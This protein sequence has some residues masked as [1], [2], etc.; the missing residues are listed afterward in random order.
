MCAALLQALMLAHAFPGE[1]NVRLIGR[2]NA[3]GQANWPLSGFEV[4]ISS[5]A[6][7]AAASSL[8]VEFDQC[9]GCQY[10][11]ETFADNVSQ[12]RT[13]INATSLT[14]VVP[15]P[16]STQYVRV[17]KVTEADLGASDGGT[18][19][20][21]S[22]AS[23]K[24]SGSTFAAVD[25]AKSTTHNSKMNALKLLVFGDSLTCGYGALGVGPCDFTA[26]T[27]S[28]AA[29]WARVTATELHAELNQVTWSGKGVVRNY[30][31]AQQT[32]EYP[33]PF[34]Y[35][36]TL[37]WNP[38]DKGFAEGD[39]LYWNPT[40]YQ[41]DMILVLLGSNDY[42]T[43]PVPDTSVFIAGFSALVQQMQGDYPHSKIALLCSPDLSNTQK[44]ANVKAAA[45]QNNVHFLQIKPTDP[46]A[47]GGCNGHPN[48]S[49]QQQMAE[50]SVIPF[51]KTILAETGPYT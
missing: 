40:T 34:Y 12:G 23:V 25:T 15:L 20:V 21:M 26:S 4:E 37:G 2:W 22:L 44:C 16:A 30:G 28:A 33:L 6:D 41:P 19:G 49:Q 50:L 47:W 17:L 42:S 18:V 36:R 51:L 24:A 14:L 35:N 29:S 27:E 39:D 38:T 8:I 10:V 3:R 13:T 31:D 48:A 32:S 9:E 45:A 11:V 5:P 7:T 43:E 46:V 1:E